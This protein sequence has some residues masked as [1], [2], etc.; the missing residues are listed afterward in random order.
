MSYAAI[1]GLGLVL[2]QGVGL[3]S[4]DAV[5]RG[6]SAVAYL[7]DMPGLEELT[8][9]AVSDFSP[10]AGAEGA[11][12]AIQFAV[13][14]ADEA[15][16]GA[17][18]DAGGFDPHRAGVL[19]TLS[20]G[21]IFALT[22]AA[23]PGAGAALWAD[24]TPDA[25]ARLI[26]GR[27]RL[28]GPIG[29]PVTACA[30]GGHALQWAVR[31]IERG[32]AD[33]VLTGAAE[34]SIHPLVLASYRRM[35]VLADARGDPPTSVRPFSLTRRGFA[36]GEGA[37]VLVVESEA[38]ARCRGAEVLA[39]VVGSAGGAQATDL[40]DV[41]AS[42]ASL[43]RLMQ[44]A[45]RRAGLGASDVDFVH[46]HG[47]ATPANDLAEAKAIRSAFG[48]HAG[49]LSV[50]STKGSHGHLLGAAAAVEM[51]LT[52]LALRRQ[53]VPATANLTDPDPAIGLDCTPLRARTRVLRYAM[54]ISSGFGGQA[55]AVCLGR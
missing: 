14:A 52:V 29:A 54:K 1:T 18:L 50:S 41:E 44:E 8:A 21:G 42:G 37:A 28:A 26:A 38:S 16:H 17:R 36:V 31:L 19:V 45:V 47:T 35:G 51:V 25:A 40:T 34:A 22:R 10:P 49:G 11:D 39:R 48:R 24:A 15:W 46:A 13:A 30:S 20:K 23:R 4:A 5:F 3:P 2:P 9:A 12:R 6:E 27:F 55:S 32:A 43:A 53:E 33:L 7:T